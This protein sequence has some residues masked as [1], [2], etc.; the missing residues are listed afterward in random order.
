[1]FQFRDMTHE[2]RASYT[3]R[4]WRR[5]IV[6]GEDA[7][8][9]GEQ[10]SS[11]STRLSRMFEDGVSVSNLAEHHV[12]Q[13]CMPSERTPC[14]DGGFNARSAGRQCSEACTA[15]SSQPKHQGIFGYF[16]GGARELT[17]ALPRQNP[18]C[19]RKGP[20]QGSSEAESST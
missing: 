17:E 8:A 15:S 13:G 2:G 12:A 20:S 1:M 3:T 10:H 9:L 16:D 6:E 14:L 18:F 5:G 11:M 19:H 4:S 7:A